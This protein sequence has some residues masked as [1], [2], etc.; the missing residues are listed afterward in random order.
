VVIR[1]A[2]EEESYVIAAVALF[3]GLVTVFSMAK[4]WLGAFWSTSPEDAPEPEPLSS[5]EKVFLLAPVAALAL[6]TVVIGLWADPLFEYARA[7]SAGLLDPNAYVEAV[8]GG[9]R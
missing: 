4:I 9:R 8:L 3:V 6:L 5:R 1:A 2:L 7:A